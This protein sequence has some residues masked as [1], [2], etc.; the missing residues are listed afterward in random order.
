MLEKPRSTLG[1]EIGCNYKNEAEGPEG[2][3]GVELCQ[4]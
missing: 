1:C 4:L 3:G 2:E